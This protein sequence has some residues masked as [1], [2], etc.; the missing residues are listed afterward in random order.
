MLKV[1]NPVASESIAL[2]SSSLPENDAAEWSATTTY[3]EGAV[4]KRSA[5]HSLYTAT[6]AI[7][8]NASNAAPENDP[9]RWTFTG[10]TNRWAML[11]ARINTRSKGNASTGGI[12][13]TVTVSGY[14]N[15]VSV[16]DMVGI[17]AMTITVSY[18][19]AIRD[20]DTI[21]ETSDYAEGIVLTTITNHRAGTLTMVYAI[22]LHKRNVSNW[23]AYFVEPFQIKTDIF[24][25]FPSRQ[26]ASI[27]IQAASGGDNSATVEIGAVMPGN[28][29]EL[30][31]FQYG[32]D[33]GI[34]DYSYK[35]TDAFGV[36]TL[37]ERDY[38]KRVS[39]SVHIDNYAINRVFSTLA[40]LRAKPAVFIGTEDYRYTPFTVFGYV[41][42][43]SLGL[44]FAAY[45]LVN[46]EVKGLS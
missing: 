15:G 28:Y 27:R 26:N 16:L 8:G 41:A 39:F 33:A 44:T 45:S 12:D 19:I 6:Q 14:C 29:V 32:A 38:V 1:L 18:A 36:T 20:S 13:T 21:T 34:E 5:T 35:S 25:G 37:V 22:S 43:F 31:D 7:T 24:V 30:G 10:P 40:A 17:T 3:A 11:D 4:V 46:V 42:N 2:I 9:S 23:S